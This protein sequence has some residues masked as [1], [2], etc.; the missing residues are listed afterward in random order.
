MYPVEQLNSFREQF[1][2]NFPNNT[3]YVDPAKYY[4]C[5]VVA[6]YIDD[7]TQR[8]SKGELVNDHTLSLQWMPLRKVLSAAHAQ[9]TPQKSPSSNVNS[10]N[11]DSRLNTPEKMISP[12]SSPITKSADI[13]STNIASPSSTSPGSASADS[14][15]PGLHRVARFIL[16]H[17]NFLQCVHHLVSSQN[18]V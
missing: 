13:A 7:L 15:S 1:A 18:A 2:R 16:S 8:F 10:P 12:V 17:R 14:T 4:A 3:Y 9:R 5:I 6:P 11:H